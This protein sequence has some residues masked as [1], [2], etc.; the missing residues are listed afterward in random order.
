MLSL[1]HV[2]LLQLLGAQLGSK[3]GEMWG[4]GAFHAPK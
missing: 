4:A 1:L 2:R 3:G